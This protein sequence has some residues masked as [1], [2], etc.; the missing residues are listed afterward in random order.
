MIT[1]KLIFRML[2]VISFVHTVSAQTKS[3][4]RGEQNAVNAAIAMVESLGG[5]DYWSQLKNVQMEYKWQPVDQSDKYVEKMVLDLTGSRSLV[6]VNGKEFKR[7][8]SNSPEHGNWV[9]VNGRVSISPES[10]EG[11]LTQAPF[12]IYRIVKGIAMGDSYYEVRLNKTLLLDGITLDFFDID[13]RIGGSITLNSKHEPV[14][15]STMDYTYTFGP[16]K[17]FGNLKAPEWTFYGCGVFKYETV[18]VV[19]SKK[20]LPTEFFGNT[21]ARKNLK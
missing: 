21:S 2:I 4:I 19:A 12:H 3:T 7:I 10:T 9:D 20:S 18:S 15:W 14:L 13:G 6:E 16:M 8:T 11:Y 5:I 17:E 1:E